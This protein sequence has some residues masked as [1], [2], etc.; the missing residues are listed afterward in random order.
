MP[1]LL[2]FLP[3]TVVTQ[4]SRTAAALRRLTA[5]L[6]L[7]NLP[8]SISIL[9]LTGILL[10]A[11]LYAAPTLANPVDRTRSASSLT[12]TTQP[13]IVVPE[14]IKQTTVRILDNSGAGSGVIIQKQRNTY[15]V[16]TCAHVVAGSQDERRTV[17]TVD[18]L[19]HPVQQLRAARLG[20]TDLALMQF[21]SRQSYQIAELGNSQHLGTGAVVYAAGF[22]NW[23]S[24]G[25]K[26]IENTR[27]WG[28]KALALTTGRVGMMLAKPLHEGYQL[29]Y[30]NDIQDG[31]SGG[32]VFNQQGQLV[33]INGRLK[34]PFQGINA[35]VFIDG[36]LPSK[37][38]FQ[39]METLSWAIPIATFQQLTQLQ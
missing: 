6:I 36:T 33:G 28:L 16:L 35:F 10:T 2:R 17:L 14:I 5:L 3:V 38:L 12:T 23:H 30:T 22:P 8:Q 39:R 18:G 20:E 29:G 34:Y 13:T 26:A 37:P 25:P 19:T 7:L 27:N 31:M 24:V 32:P 21:A 4:V 1:H 11:G 9:L 15:T